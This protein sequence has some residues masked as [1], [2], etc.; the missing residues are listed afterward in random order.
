MNF[1]DEY[2][3]LM[4]KPIENIREDIFFRASNF[5][6]EPWYDDFQQYMALGIC[7]PPEKYALQIRKA[8]KIMGL[9]THTANRSGKT[10][11]LPGEKRQPERETRQKSHHDRER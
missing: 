10:Y 2:R 3:E 11:I 5:Q 4:D 1:E 9:P 6:D 7:Q 8:L